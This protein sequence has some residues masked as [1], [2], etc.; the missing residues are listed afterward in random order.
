MLAIAFHAAISRDCDHR[1]PFDSFHCASTIA[2]VHFQP[3]FSP[4]PPSLLLFS[5]H[6]A[7]ATRRV[8]MFFL[9]FFFLFSWK[10]QTFVSECFL[11]PR[12]LQTRQISEW[13]SNETANETKE[14]ARPEH[15]SKSMVGK[16]TPIHTHTHTQSA[17]NQSRR[18][19]RSYDRI[20]I[21][22]RP[23]LIQ[24]NNYQAG[25]LFY[26][27]LVFRSRVERAPST[28]LN[29]FFS[30]P[31]PL[32]SLSLSLSFVL[33]FSERRNAWNSSACLSRGSRFR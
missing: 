10:L 32:L 30:P 28:R 29:F 23:L 20:P 3:Y 24:G 18:R 33:S 31:S 1:H 16:I 19:Q 11:S 9:F 5:S 2:F 8:T 12:N 6:S 15:R 26:S 14:A 25:G 21:F 27:R 13:Q 22:H 4:P 17:V 7:I